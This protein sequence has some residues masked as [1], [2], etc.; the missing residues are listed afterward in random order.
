MN[1]FSPSLF[2]PVSDW[3]VAVLLLFL[4]LWET[5][6]AC[7]HCQNVI[8]YKFETQDIWCPNLH[9][10][11]VRTWLFKTH[12]TGQSQKRWAQWDLSY[13]KTDKET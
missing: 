8:I 4:P 6:N 1:T 10:Q 3:L 2:L 7:V 12:K 9:V 11:D 5:Q 13:S